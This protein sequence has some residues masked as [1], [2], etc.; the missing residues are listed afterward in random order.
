MVGIVLVSHSRSLALAARELVEGVAGSDLAIAAAGGAGSGRTAL[1]TDAMEIVEAIQ[2]VSGDEGVLVITDVGSALLS[3]DAAMEFLDAETRGKVRCC[4]APFIEGALAAGVAATLGGTLEEVLREAESSLRH[5]LSHYQPPQAPATAAKS[6]V[7]SRKARL[8]NPHGLHARPG[9]RFAREAARATATIEVRNATR[10]RG[11]VSARSLSGLASLELLEGDE[12]E[13]LAGGPDAELALRNL[14]A[15]VESGFGELAS[16]PAAPEPADSELVA[17]AG[18]IAAGPL[19]R[20]VSEAAVIPQDPAS[21][22]GP[23]IDRLANAL[24]AARAA[25]IR[26]EATLASSASGRTGIFEAQAQM[27][28]DPRLLDAAR[29]G[30][31]NQQR[32]AAR[33]WAEASEEIAREFEELQNPYLRQR[34]SD[35]RDAAASVLEALGIARPGFALPPEPGILVVDSMTP[36]QAAGLDARSVLGVVLLEDTCPSHAA[37]VLRALGIPAVSGARRRLGIEAINRGGTALID[38]SAGRLVL[39][40]G[41]EELDRARTRMSR[42]REITAKALAECKEPSITQDGYALPVLANLSKASETGHALG[43]GAEGIGLFRTEFL[44]L[45]RSEAPN[46]QEQFEALRELARG[47]NG[48]IAVVRTFDIGGDKEAPCLHLPREANPFLGE[49]GIRLALHRPEHFQAHLRAI[50][51]AGESGG[52][53]LMFPMIRDLRELADALEALREAHDALAREGIPHASQL[54]VGIMIEVPS[55]AAL[56]D[57]LAPKVDFVSI[58]TND[59]TQY[60]LAAERGNPRLA[61]FQDALHPGVLRVIYQ[62][63]LGARRHGKAIAIC[64]E[65]AADPACAA[66][67][68]GLGADELSLTPEAIPKV[69]ALIRRLDSGEM[70]QTAQQALRLSS[71]DEVRALP[72]VAR[73]FEADA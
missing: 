54:P 63:I 29:A 56:I 43:R 14:A 64:G 8:C 66:I 49:R 5:K 12:M 59:L 35:V 4:A 32:N 31:E 7:K 17:V 47:L 61:G 39:D 30:I 73:L 11:P 50:L 34:A 69:K 18:G 72:E 48:A 52:L 65:A 38:G 26:Q 1:G 62:I 60:L 10:N 27:L 2:S 36:G 53:R 70:R 57:Q 15:L 67:F 44:F 46:E 13:I 19:I 6:Q 3:A 68:L 45:G 42:Q 9:A 37:L 28:E 58:G 22:A 20:P 71:A 23:E 24:E 40:P 51:R 33:A 25:L 41:N 21:A 55:A 16:E